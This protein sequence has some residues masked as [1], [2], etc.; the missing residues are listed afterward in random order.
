[1]FELVL[2]TAKQHVG[3]VNWERAVG[4]R[5]HAHWNSSLSVPAHVQTV[6][7][8]FERSGSRADSLLHVTFAW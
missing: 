8:M 4:A 2:E 6:Y 5:A 7:C 3:K 1:L